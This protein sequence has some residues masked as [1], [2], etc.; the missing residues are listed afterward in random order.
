VSARRLALLALL[1]APGAAAQEPDSLRL[2]GPNGGQASVAVATDRGFAAVPLRTLETLGWGVALLSDGAE[3]RRA[4][5][6]LRLRD[7]VPFFR[8]NDDLLQLTHAPYRVGEQLWIPVQLL[9]DFL[10]QRLDDDY[11]FEPE[12][13]VVRAKTAGAWI[14]RA[15][16]AEPERVAAPPPGLATPAVAAGAT[17]APSARRVVIID[18]G[19]GGQ[20]PGARGP[21]GVREKDVALAIGLALAAEL[22]Q[23]GDIDVHLT[24]ASDR[25]VPLWERGE[26]ATEIKGERAGVFISIHANSGGEL[27]ARGFETYFLA[28]ARTEHERRVAALENEAFRPAGGADDPVASDPAL[29]FILK[30]LN[31]LDHQHWSALL[32]ELVQQHVDPIH[33]GPN[34]GIKQGPLA[35]ITN[36][37]MPS[38]LLEI[39]FISNRAE[40]RLL[41][42]REFQTNAARALAGAIAEFFERYP[43]GPGA[44]APR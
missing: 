36:A 10:P 9:S 26:W 24:R 6:T 16:P 38:V 3:A 31:N 32:A 11:A 39:G 23:R 13:F 40:E 2:A 21:G 18:P 5:H 17:P 19:H 28:D 30:D 7:G 29:D 35:V 14:P 33:S 20:D 42:S 44:E 34:R 41:A 1:L 25:Q 4:P 15:L 22:E 8:W 12:R 43:P 27:A 37:L